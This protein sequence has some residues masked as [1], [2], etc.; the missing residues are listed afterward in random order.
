MIFTGTFNA[1]TYTQI[2]RFHKYCFFPI[3]YDKN[4]GGISFSLP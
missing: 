4:L 2:K 1:V 3:N